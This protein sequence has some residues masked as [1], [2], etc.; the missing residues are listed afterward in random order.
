VGYFPPESAPGIV[1]EN[2][3]VPPTSQS[4]VWQ[5]GATI[6]A[7]MTAKEPDSTESKDQRRY[8]VKPKYEKLIE[9]KS[10]SGYSQDLINLVEDCLRMEMEDRPS[11][12]ELLNMVEDYMPMYAEGMDR[13]GTLSWVK[14]KS[15]EI[16]GPL[17]ADDDAH[18][19]TDAGTGTATG[20]KRKATE[21]L[22]SPPDA[23]RIKAETALTRRLAY[24]ASVIKG[25]RPVPKPHEDDQDFKLGWRKRMVYK[26]VDAMF[27]PD[28]FFE[29][30]DPG[31][32]DYLKLGTVDRNRLGV[33]LVDDDDDDDDGDDDE[34]GKD[35][36]AKSLPPI[37][38][39]KPKKPI[40]GA[41][42]S[43]DPYMLFSSPAKPTPA[44]PVAAKPAPDKPAPDKSAPAEP[45]KP[46]SPGVKFHSN[47]LFS[48][49]WSSGY[50]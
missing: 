29:T 20:E 42:T 50:E 5:V 9:D 37:T 31:P 17:V 24:V 4:N 45:T 35:D 38:P 23:K 48:T 7:A 39:A 25:I 40:K 10:W 16:D 36:K 15:S 46:H 49:H 30:A 21:P 33:V 19:D 28:T 3:R 14:Q 41:G 26:V 1:P 22:G 2:E 11:P 27:D 32:I 18:I 34:D 13:W 44:K 8:T 6:L 43:V 12:Q 47:D